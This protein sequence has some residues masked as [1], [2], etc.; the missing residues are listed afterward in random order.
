MCHFLT[1]RRNQGRLGGVSAIAV[2]I[3]TIQPGLGVCVPARTEYRNRPSR[4]LG[5]VPVFAQVLCTLENMQQGRPRPCWTDWLYSRISPWI[6]NESLRYAGTAAAAR[7][8]LHQQT[9]WLKRP[10]MRASRGSVLRRLLVRSD[11]APPS[12]L[13]HACRRNPCVIFRRLN[14]Q[15]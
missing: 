3:A 8:L 9:C 11:A 4:S 7:A 6:R 2:I 10:G 1:P 14:T 12:P 15:T 13:Q 5:S